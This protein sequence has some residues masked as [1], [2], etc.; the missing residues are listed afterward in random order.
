[1]HGGEL[2]QTSHSSKPEHGALSSPEGEVRVFCPIVLVAADLLATFVPDILHRSAVG[3]AAVR[4]DD[5]RIDVSFHCF[6]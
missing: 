2:L 4:D 3:R 5:L 1:M 6:S